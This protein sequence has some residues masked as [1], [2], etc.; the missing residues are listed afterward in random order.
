[1]SKRKPDQVIEFRI[2]L[3]D[4]ER[5]LLEHIVYVEGTAKAFNQFTEPF[6]EI[7]KDVSAMSLIFGALAA[8]GGWKYVV[9]PGIE[10][11]EDL[12]ADFMEQYDVERKARTAA[13]EAVGGVGGLVPGPLGPLFR[14]LGIY[15][16]RG[17]DGGGGGGGGGF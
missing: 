3:Q 7:V 14:F 5:E 15:I 6:V 16:Q 4:K 2:S 11:A 9:S 13:G 10:T 12:F 8:Y 17:N 1:M